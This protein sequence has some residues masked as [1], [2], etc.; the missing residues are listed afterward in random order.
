VTLQA[1]EGKR[2][3]PPVSEP[4]LAKHMP[5]AVATPEPDEEPPGQ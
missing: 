5:L 1:C 3:E 4:V 2:I